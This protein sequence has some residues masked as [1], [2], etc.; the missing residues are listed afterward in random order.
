MIF[1][2]TALREFE[3]RKALCDQ[4]DRA[5]A[6]EAERDRYREAL[7]RIGGPAGLEKIV[8]WTD[9][10][11]THE[12]VERVVPKQ[13]LDELAASLGSLVLTIDGEWGQGAADD[14]RQLLAKHGYDAYGKRAGE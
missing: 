10:H 11:G 2:K 13:A 5:E 3:I 14:I 8:T 12:F 6:A 4:Y 1:S 7:E 9:E